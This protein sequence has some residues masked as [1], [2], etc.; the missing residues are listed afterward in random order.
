MFV[1]HNYLLQYNGIPVVGYAHIFRYR[2]NLFFQL[3]RGCFI[4]F[5]YGRDLRRARGKIS[6]NS[7][8]FIWSY[9]CFSVCHGKIKT[10]D[11]LTHVP[12]GVSAVKKQ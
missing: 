2:H 4:C 1:L 8:N 9:A 3:L 5:H 12:I 10:T 11:T 7:F 6:R